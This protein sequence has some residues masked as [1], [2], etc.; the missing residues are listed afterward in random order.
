[1][2]ALLVIIACL[3]VEPF[4]LRNVIGLWISGIRQLF[5][6]ILGYNAFGQR[7]RIFVTKPSTL[8][9]SF[10]GVAVK[11]VIIPQFYNIRQWMRYGGTRIA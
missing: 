9:E 10:S 3:F 5:T 6:D 2:Y 1:M 11:L 7:F 4:T 8:H